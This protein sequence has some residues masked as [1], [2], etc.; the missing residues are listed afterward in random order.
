M[1]FR[2]ELVRDIRAGRKTATRRPVKAGKPC[3]Y[4]P[5]KSYAVQPGRGKS[6][7]CRIKVTSVT[8][9][10]VGDITH[11]DAVAEGFR[12][13]D[14]FKAYW[15]ALHE[16]A[17][18]KHEIAML[19]E[20]ENDD[21]V[22]LD[23]DTWITRRSIDLFDRNHARRPVWAITFTLDTAP[24]GR[25]LALQSDELY[26]NNPARALPDEP[27]AV[28]PDTQKRITQDAGMTTRQ[29]QAI[30]SAGRDKDRALLSREDQLA[31]LQRAAR[32]RSVD[33][34]REMWALQNSLGSAQDGR[35][36]AKV[37]KT[38]AKVFRMAA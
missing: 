38:E 24:V 2:P 31:R 11:A 6:A 33:I 36:D 8:R 25:F 32:L 9:E 13:T 4:R 37:R 15:I 34:T 20:A 35:F 29:W 12:T 3:R 21:G 18:L 17:W 23:R 27:E 16:P 30:E 1:I 26:T 10:L 28:D 19:E 22:V 7:T 14:D 5:G